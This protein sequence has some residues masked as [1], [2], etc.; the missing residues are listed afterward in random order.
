MSAV[1]TD[2]PQLNVALTAEIMTFT[3]SGQSNVPD[4]D[5]VQR[6]LTNTIAFAE[7]RIADN[8]DVSGRRLRIS[9]ERFEVFLKIIGFEFRGN[10]MSVMF[11]GALK[12]TPFSPDDVQLR[13]AEVTSAIFDLTEQEK[14]FYVSAYIQTI[15]SDATQ[16]VES[17]DVIEASMQPSTSSVPTPTPSDDVPVAPRCSFNSNILASDPACEACPYDSSI[18]RTN[19]DCEPCSH[20]PSIGVTS[21]ECRPCPSNTSISATSAACK[22]GRTAPYASDDQ[23]CSI[24]GEGRVMTN[25][26]SLVYNLYAGELTTC[27]EAQVIGE[28]GGYTEVQCRDLQESFATKCGC[29]DESLL[30]CQ[31]D[32]LRLASDEDCKPC[33]HK[34][35]VG[36]F[37][38]ECDPCPNDPSVSK[39][40]PACNV[41]SGYG[42]SLTSNHADHSHPSSST[43]LA[44]TYYNLF[45]SETQ[46]L[47][48]PSHPKSRRSLR[49]PSGTDAGRSR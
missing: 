10:S 20:N 36:V 42:R 28:Q 41:Q 17:F 38:E 2:A 26:D 34:D 49:S 22:N 24:C 31:F 15:P 23:A 47:D 40:D 18:G 35:S 25:M 7:Q 21:A 39:M 45:P 5:A 13:T 8:F 37:S 48:Q 6:I 1:P 14:D 44:R 33:P 43:L 30:V 16:N 32:S 19:I 3:L 27:Q 46:N 4:E 12:Y 29:M 11:G 9:R